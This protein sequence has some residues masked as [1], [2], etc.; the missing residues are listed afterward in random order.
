MFGPTPTV[1]YGPKQLN[2]QGAGVNV[3]SDTTNTFSLSLPLPPGLGAKGKIT[4]TANNAFGDTSEFANDVVPTPTTLT[5]ALSQSIINEGDTVTLSGSFPV[6]P[7][8]QLLAVAC[9][10]GEIGILRSESDDL[11]GQREFVGIGAG[12]GEVFEIGGGGGKTTPFPP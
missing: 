7:E 5:L 12:V 9:G 2:I 8:V 4:A 3:G 6:N 10:K 11:L 1:T